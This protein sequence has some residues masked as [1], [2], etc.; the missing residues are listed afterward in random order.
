MGYTNLQFFDSQSYS[1][2]SLI[3]VIIAVLF[4]LFSIYHYFNSVLVAS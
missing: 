2:N 4:I 3:T 1:F